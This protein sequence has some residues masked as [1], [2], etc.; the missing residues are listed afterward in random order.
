MKWISMV[1]TF[2]GLRHEDERSAMRHLEALH[3]DTLSGIAHGIV[4]QNHK[5]GAVGDWVDNNLPLFERLM[6]IKADMK[7]EVGRE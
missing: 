6:R 7:M 2:D 5:Y 1:E 3:A 4:A